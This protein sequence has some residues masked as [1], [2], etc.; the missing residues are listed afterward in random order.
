VTVFVDTSALYALLDKADD[1]HDAAE[2]TFRGLRGQHL[3]T[4]AYVIV[5][6]AALAARR[7]GSTSTALLFDG[8]LGVVETE[9][10]DASLHREAIT[11]YRAAGPRSVSLVDRTS[12]AFMRRR[13][14]GSAFAFDADFAAAVFEV[15]PM[16]G[17]GDSGVVAGG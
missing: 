8:L 16:Q 6:T 15:V 17:V 11:A 14:I 4:H 10:V 2:V 5:E 12:F 7:L 13:A 1:E 9:A 3:V